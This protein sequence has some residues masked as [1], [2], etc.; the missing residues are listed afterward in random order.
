M[1]C[2]LMAVRTSA[3]AAAKDIGLVNGS[4]EEEA[5]AIKIQ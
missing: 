1:L 4:E 3:L 2:H 5:I